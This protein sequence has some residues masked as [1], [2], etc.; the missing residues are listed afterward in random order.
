MLTVLGVHQWFSDQLPGYLLG[1]SGLSP[2]CLMLREIQG[3]R[4]VAFLELIEDTGVPVLDVVK[5]LQ[6][7]TI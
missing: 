1:L 7:G 4:G 6:T 2:P 3:S 5:P